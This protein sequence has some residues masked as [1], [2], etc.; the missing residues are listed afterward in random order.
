MFYSIILGLALYQIG[1]FLSHPNNGFPYVFAVLGLTSAFA[2]ISLLQYSG[3]NMLYKENVR[4]IH[5]K[6][7]M[8]GLTRPRFI[9][10]FEQSGKIRKRLI[11]L[12]GTLGGGRAVAETA[13]NQ[14]KDAGYN[15]LS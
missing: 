4:E 1:Y 3:V 11:I 14:L 7:G 12:P 2:L 9:V 15:L 13:Q 8:P 10:H 5:Y 6:K